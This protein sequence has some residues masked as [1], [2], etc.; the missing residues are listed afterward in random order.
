MPGCEDAEGRRPVGDPL[1][2]SDAAVGQRCRDTRSVEDVRRIVEISVGERGKLQFSVEN[3]TD[4]LDGALPVGFGGIGVPL[5]N[6]TIGATNA[7]VLQPRTLRF[8]YRESF[9]SGPIFER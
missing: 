3:L 5:A 8:M 2:N 9:G 6:G 1:A 7:N 4:T